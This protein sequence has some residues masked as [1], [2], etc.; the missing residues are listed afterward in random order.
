MLVVIIKLT[1]SLFHF[2]PFF[3]SLLFVVHCAQTLAS[4]AAGVRMQRFIGMKT[5][6]IFMQSKTKQ[7]NKKLYLIP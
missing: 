5:K 3:L 2:I 1:I 4:K 7:T 6:G